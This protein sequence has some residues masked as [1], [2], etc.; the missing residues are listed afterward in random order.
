VDVVTTRSVLIYVREKNRAFRAFHRALRP[1]GRI[2]LFEPVNNYFPEDPNDFW[3]FDARAV[4]DLVEKIWIYEGW[5]D[6]SNAD[7]PMMNFDERDL[8][9]HAEEAGFSEVHA[10]LV[11]DVEPG[12]WVEDW[13]RLMGIAPNPNAHTTGE[14]IQGALTAD[15]AERF[16]RHLRPSVDAGLAVKRSAFAYLWAVK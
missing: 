1:G 3:G 7:D 14:A 2:S 4:R 11:I 8:L 12:T 9:R 10:E 13:D 5:N 16:E 6:K 15:E